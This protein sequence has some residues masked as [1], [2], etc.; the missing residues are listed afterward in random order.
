MYRVQIGVN[1]TLLANPTAVGLAENANLTYLS[2]IRV[3]LQRHTHDWDDVVW[4]VTLANNTSPHEVLAV[5][6]PDVFPSTS[7][8]GLI[9]RATLG[10][11]ALT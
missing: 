8:G 11:L 6:P 3:R 4:L 1:C 5:R 7:A 2:M 10:K 9:G